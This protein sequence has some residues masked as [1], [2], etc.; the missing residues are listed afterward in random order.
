MGAMENQSPLDPRDAGAWA[1]QAEQAML[2]GDY[3]NAAWSLAA[4]TRAAP[5]N[6]GLWSNL[7]LAFLHASRPEEAERAAQRAVELD[8]RHAFAWQ[9]LGQ[10]R[11]D[12]GRFEDAEAA[13]RQSLRYQP[14]SAAAQY[15]LAAAL[16]FRGQWASSR[17]AYVEAARRVPNSAD[18][19]IGVANASLRMGERREAV[20]ALRN[21]AKADPERGAE[22][23]S[24][25]LVAMQQGDE[26]TAEEVF[27]AHQ[28]WARR[29]QLKAVS[30]PLPRRVG[31]RIRVGYVS[32]A[33]HASA[34]AFALLPVLERHDRER[35][36]IACYSQGGPH[37]TVTE[38]FRAL[39]AA[40]RDTTPM[41][42]IDLW[43]AIQD[44]G[45]DVLVDL[46]G[47]TPGNRLTVFPLRPAPVQ[48][49]WLDYFNTTGLDAIDGIL[50][51]D[52]SL[53]APL[54]QRFVER[55][56]A[57]GPCRYPYAPPAD[58]R[59]VAPRP[60][61]PV[62]FGSFA[63]LSKVCSTT[64]AAWGAAM[65][66]VP[67][68]RLVL[69]NDSLAD[70]AVRERLSRDLVAHGVERSRVEMRGA[71]EHRRM[72]AEYAD[73]DVV[74]DTAPYN[75]GITTLEALYMG[76]PV[77]TLAGTTLIG[78]QGAGILA[79]LGHP[80]WVAQ[81]AAQFGNIA[82]SLAA[83]PSR[84]G[85]IQ[86]GL[87]ESLLRSPLCDAEGF[88]RRLEALYERMLGA[89]TARIR[90]EEAQHLA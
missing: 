59:A 50:A 35:F 71:S 15:G 1:Q 17:S 88:T 26:F 46:A 80:E 64:L 10:A 4:A 32:P 83:D 58:V 65:S 81:D 20:E 31:G 84:L 9:H 16:A 44:D 89:W 8:P 56:V 30:T 73:V 45:I 82:A 86:L 52:A 43:R 25:E 74:L 3:E 77:V 78:R 14:D 53:V 85:A 79:A 41:N 18:P 21:A 60:E 11:G 24:H 42:D 48:L 76:R 47:H 2:T 6:A 54:Q 69:K 75:G 49:S 13:Y 39:A 37:D 33:F 12:L 5:G 87:R 19:W 22:V 7:A 27:A 38:R 23:G 29:F 68:A 67:G 34:M 40:W 62:V 66:A 72:M 51:D 63:R 36:E 55:L 61:R 70:P 57:V 28:D 90:Q